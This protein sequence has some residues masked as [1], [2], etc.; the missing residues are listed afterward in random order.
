ME[1]LL[2]DQPDEVKE[3]HEDDEDQAPDEES[4]EEEDSAIA[5]LEEIQYM[6][7]CPVFK[8]TLRLQKDVEY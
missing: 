6:Y 2:K 5:E 1:N 3:R 8:T 7:R 4:E